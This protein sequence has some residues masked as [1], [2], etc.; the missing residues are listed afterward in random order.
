MD[1]IRLFEVHHKYVL[2][3]SN[4]VAKLFSAEGVHEVK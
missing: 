2:L 1:Q 4:E 3:V